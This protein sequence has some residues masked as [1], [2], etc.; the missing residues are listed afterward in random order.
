MANFQRNLRTKLERNI[1]KCSTKFLANFQSNFQR[2]QILQKCVKN[3]VEILLKIQISLK[4]ELKVFT[5]YY[6]LTKS[7]SRTKL[8]KVSL[9]YFINLTI[10]LHFEIMAI[11]PWCLHC[12]KCQDDTVGRAS[13]E[14]QLTVCGV[15]GEI[16]RPMYNSFLIQYDP[17]AGCSQNKEHVL[18]GW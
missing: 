10:Y 5:S 2:I 9:P 13:M 1:N 17:A 16:V 14:S 6:F 12:V 15:Q 3:V 7:K 4:I 8:F 11:N 18:K